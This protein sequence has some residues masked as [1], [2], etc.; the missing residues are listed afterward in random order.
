MSRP[1]LFVPSSCV[2]VCAWAM[3]V[4][5]E[6]LRAEETVDYLQRV[7]PILAAH[8]YSCHG[9][10]KQKNGLRLDTIEQMKKGGTS[11]PVIVPGISAKSLLIRQ[12]TNS[13]DAKRMPPPSEG[14]RLKPAEVALIKAWI[15]QGASGPIDEKPETSPSE[16]WAFKAPV[17]PP[18]PVVKNALW[19]IRNP[20][21]A[22]IASEWEKQGLKPQAPAD[23]RI[24]LRR[25]YLDLIGLPP[26][27][28]EQEAFLADL[29]EDAYEKVVDRLLASKQYGER[30][31]RHWMDV[32]RYSDWW[33]LGVEVRN[34]QKH[35]WHW[36]DWIIESLNAD[37]GYDHMVREMLAADEL[38][39]TDRER[40]RATGFLARQ[41][42]I[43]NRN[44][45]MEE[46]VEH[47]SKAFLGLTVNCSKCHDHK[48]DPIAQ[49][50][51]Y[52]LRAFFEPYQVRL[53]MAKGEAD[54]AKDGIPRVFDCNANAPTY[55]FVRGDEKN[56]RKDKSLEPGLPEFLR[57]ENLKITPVALPPVAQEPGLREEVLQTHL[58][59]AERQI[60]LADAALEQAKKSLA[61]AAKKQKAIDGK[62][63]VTLRVLAKD[64]FA[65]EKTG[66]W[67]MKAGQ[68]KY[69]NGRIE[70]S[71][72]G[73][74]RAVLR[75]KQIPPND[76]QARFKFTITGGQ[77][78][79]SV[80][81]SFDVADANEALVYLSAWKDGPKLQIAYKQGGDY[82]YPAQGTQPRSVKLNEANEL[83]IRVR[84]PLINVSVNGQHA[85][86][87]KLPILRRS[88]SMEL[89]T[90]DAKAEFHAFE[91]MAL[92]E[93]VKL[94]EPG[95]PA[96]SPSAPLTMEQARLALAVA[97]KALASAKLQ[98]DLFKA[99]AAA[100]RARYRQPPAADAKALA[101]QA[102][103]AERQYAVATAE[104]AL[105]RAELEQAQAADA[106]K[107]ETG[108][109]LG[110]AK[111]ALAK[112]RRELDTPGEKYSSLRGSLKSP[113][114][115]L[116]TE[117]SR[118]KP[119]PAMSTGRRSALANW[120]TDS[121]NPLTARVAVNHIWARHFGKPLVATVFD[122]GRKG[123]APTHPE[124]LDYLAVEFRDS[125]WSMKKLHRLIV[126]SN[127]FRLSS[128]AKDVAPTNE[129]Q[130]AQ[131]SS[132]ALDPE[133][134]FYWHMNN[135]RMEAQVIRDSLLHLSG[136]LDL[137]MYG[138]SIPVSDDNS[139]RRSL[140]YL[141]SHN[142]RQSFLDTF[143]NASVLECYRRAESIV[144]QQALALENSPL[145]AH[146][147]DKIARA[148]NEKSDSAF[149]KV[150]FEWVLGS[151]PDKD[152]V[153]DC[154]RSLK[155]LQEIAVREKKPDGALRARINLI[156]ALL[157]H[158]DFVTIR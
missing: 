31:G 28:E 15:D 3:L 158:N 1:R 137:T 58:L 57:F 12:I 35:M 91:L 151:S 26:T 132:H 115:N 117:E 59:M 131:R 68:W 14:D 109:K 22:F 37:K 69:R 64:D 55:L 16:H 96:K 86:A 27:R 148:M 94:V 95:P 61:L 122:F 81:L 152:E 156:Q 140:Y 65:S 29:S 149:I 157:N 30:W 130:T 36:R 141:H 102:A 34:S 145:V 113:E 99:R 153:D 124:L 110:T 119:Y 67:E 4:P 51:F 60:A 107:A 123:A 103:R 6:D 7:K 75:L 150:A 93:D 32:W 108:K 48:Y 38:Y 21:D 97:E 78:W 56:P 73:S 100:D 41:Y 85:L 11:G 121:R 9:G 80:G 45:W 155:E 43:F 18:I 72:D 42:F 74:T 127:A 142:E 47:T 53:D 126:T 5:A 52:R 106:K 111:E 83:T 143:D 114:S 147:A 49:Q 39:P 10:L 50:D 54:F 8:C 33:G 101:Q 134:R 19:T 79:K 44:T 24:L 144:P 138:P 2:V 23:R 92:A 98:P 63:D 154:E 120:M 66:L 62:S 87:Y 40:L 13:V 125:G 20:I 25:V 17:R 146:A 116:E 88:G 70:Q 46:V 84:G 89:I 104:E 77:L 71:Q 105:A 133:N 128:S 118:A 112:A 129:G 135:T 139:R 76:F 136:E 82:I 90:Y